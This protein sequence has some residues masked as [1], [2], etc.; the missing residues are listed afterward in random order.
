M[1]STKKIR[2]S[3]ALLTGTGTLGLC[4]YM[5]CPLLPAL[6]HTKLGPYPKPVNMHRRCCRP[7][8]IIHPVESSCDNWLLPLFPV[9]S[10]L[11]TNVVKFRFPSFPFL[12]QAFSSQ[13]PHPE[14]S[15]STSTED[16]PLVTPFPP[17]FVALSMLGSLLGTYAIVSSAARSF[18]L[19][20]SCDPLASSFVKE[21]VALS[22]RSPPPAPGEA[23]ARL[24]VYYHLCFNPN[25]T[26]KTCCSSPLARDFFDKK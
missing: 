13:C 4:N 5:S 8:E 25:S 2:N 6:T 17:V 9:N 11:L 16:C 10:V 7:C 12:P 1:S 26:L 24:P 3:P 21:V 15:P 19:L 23:A 20:Y 18:L 14:S 22:C